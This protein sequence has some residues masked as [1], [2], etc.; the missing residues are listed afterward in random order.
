M[1]YIYTCICVYMC[2][3]M[4][5]CVVSPS[6]D[7][8]LDVSVAFAACRQRVAVAIDGRLPVHHRMPMST[9]SDSDS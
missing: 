8:Q 6:R 2:V 3:Y 5:I 7:S 9:C 4:Y 1:Y